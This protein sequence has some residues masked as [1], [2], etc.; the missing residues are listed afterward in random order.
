MYIERERE[1]MGVRGR[2]REIDRQFHTKTMLIR[3]FMFIREAHMVS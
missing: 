3:I 1:K 2:E